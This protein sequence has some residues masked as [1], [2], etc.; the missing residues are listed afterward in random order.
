MTLL[1]AVLIV[2]AVAMI[3]LGQAERRQASV[4]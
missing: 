2:G 1:A 4:R 3:V